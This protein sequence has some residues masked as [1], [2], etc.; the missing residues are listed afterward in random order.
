MSMRTVYVFNM[1]IMAIY[2]YYLLADLEVVD[3]LRTVKLMK[4][5]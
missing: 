3:V 4:F 5:K 2:F 1:F